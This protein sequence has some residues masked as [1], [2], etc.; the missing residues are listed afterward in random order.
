MALL[1]KLGLCSSGDT[2]FAEPLTGGVASDIAKVAVG[3]QLKVGSFQRSER[4]IKWNECL[5]IQDELGKD[6]FVGG[7]PLTYTWWGKR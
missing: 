6:A 7:T 3:G 4:M 2:I 5:R 1:L